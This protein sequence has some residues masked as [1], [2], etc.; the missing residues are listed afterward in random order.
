MKVVLYACQQQTKGQHIS[1]TPT[2]QSWFCRRVWISLLGPLGR[3]QEGKES[4]WV[5]MS[6][7]LRV[8]MVWRGIWRL[9][10]GHSG[11]LTHSGI[12]LLSASGW[13]SSCLGLRIKGRRVSKR[14]VHTGY[15]ESCR[16]YTMDWLIDG[17]EHCLIM[18]HIWNQWKE[19]IYSASSHSALH[20]FYRTRQTWNSK[21]CTIVHRKNTLD[22]GAKC[23]VPK[24][25]SRLCF[26]RHSYLLSTLRGKA[27]RSASLM[28]YH[29]CPCASHYVTTCLWFVNVRE[30]WWMVHLC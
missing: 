21:R 18:E 15:I 24:T 1:H 6:G 11:M 25:A 16:E 17:L 7:S 29:H 22:S 26:A 4:P 20:P 30:L 14:S 10:W 5:E 8:V 27:M 12:N 9:C 23:L 19:K 28:T 3:W 2:V 13:W